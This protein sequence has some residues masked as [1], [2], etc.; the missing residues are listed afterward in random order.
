MKRFILR[1]AI[2]AVLVCMTVLV[3][4]FTLTPGAT[5]EILCRFGTGFVGYPARSLSM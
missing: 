4:S 2:L 3:I 1:R 5:H